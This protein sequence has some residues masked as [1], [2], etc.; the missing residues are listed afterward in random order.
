M[1]MFQVYKSV[2]ST[3]GPHGRLDE[4][5][6]QIIDLGVCQ[7]ILIG[8][9]VEFSIQ[10]RVSVKDAGLESLFIIGA[11]ESPRMREL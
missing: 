11:R 7:A 6:D 1:T 2:S 10:D 9:D 8:S 5:S 3:F 4:I